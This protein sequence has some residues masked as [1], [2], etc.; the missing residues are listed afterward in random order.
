VEI[1]GGLEHYSSD[2]SAAIK[3]LGKA[4][5]WESPSLFSE[6]EPQPVFKQFYDLRI[7]LVGYPYTNCLEYLVVHRERVKKDESEI[8]SLL[9]TLAIKMISPN[10]SERISGISA[11]LGATTS[12]LSTC[13]ETSSGL[14]R[15]F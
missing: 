5:I 2:F 7:F 8:C 9:N 11:Y 15:E 4:L 14:H 13:T 12:G 6:Q 1:E 3:R 10:V